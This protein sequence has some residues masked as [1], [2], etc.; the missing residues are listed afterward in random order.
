MPFVYLYSL[1]FRSISFGVDSG[2]YGDDDGRD[3][4]AGGIVVPAAR[5]LRL[6]HLDEHDVE[7]QALQEHPHERGEKEVVQDTGDDRTQNLNNDK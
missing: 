3:A 7:L 6:E 5:L 1:I 4:V 2:G